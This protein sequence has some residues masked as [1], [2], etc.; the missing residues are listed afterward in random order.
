MSKRWE[1]IPTINWI[2]KVKSWMFIKINKKFIYKSNR[3][4]KIEWNKWRKE[5]WE[6]WE[7]EYKFIKKI[8]NKHVKYE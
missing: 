4:N 3:W 6:Y 5:G 7:F 2:D 8:D 1:W